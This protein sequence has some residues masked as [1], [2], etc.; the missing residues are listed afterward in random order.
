MVVVVEGQSSQLQDISGL[1]PLRLDSEFPQSVRIGNNTSS[2]IILNTGAQQ[3]CPLSPLLNFYT[4][5]CGQIP[6]QFD[7]QVC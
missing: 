7:F 3:G 2:T 4:Y 5:D 6:H 1:D